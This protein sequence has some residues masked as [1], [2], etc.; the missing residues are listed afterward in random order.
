M[1][2]V[3]VPGGPGGF[4]TPSSTGGQG[5]DFV[6]ADITLDGHLD[7]INDAAEILPGNGDGTFGPPQAFD[8]FVPG[9]TIV[10]F[11]RDG[12]PDIVAAAEQGTA[13]ILVNLRRDN[14]NPPTVDAGRDQTIQYG[15]QFGDGEI[16]LFASG[17]DPDLHALTYEWRDENGNVFSSGDGDAEPPTMLPGTHTFTVTAS[18]NRGGTASDSLT[19]TVLPEKE[20]VTHVGAIP[21]QVQGNWSVQSDPTAAGG[22]VLRDTNAGLPK[23]TAPSA[24]PSGYA[25]FFVL[26][27]PTQTYKLWVRLKADQDHW[28]NDSLW[29][30]FDHAADQNGRTFAPGST[31]G[32]EVVLEECSGCGEAGWGWRDDAW[33]SR[34]AMSALTLKFTQGGYQRVRVQTRED[35]V[36]IDQLVLSAEQFRT[37]RP[38]TVKND[39]TIVPATIR[40]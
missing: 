8:A 27:D 11:N 28:T 29:L 15:F 35:G 16:E 38:G 39:T 19:I 33:G 26:V 2:V 14:N 31:S 17:T 32:I 30:Q 40:P 34:G 18:D 5:F 3:I 36:S 10:D 13:Q 1:G 21:S 6:L 24:N 22:S 4:G 37:T 9:P 23:V 7:A 12:L 25:E 20:V